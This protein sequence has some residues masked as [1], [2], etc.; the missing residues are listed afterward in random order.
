MKAE[1]VIDLLKKGKVEDALMAIDGA[2][3]RKEMAEKLIEFAGTLNYLKGHPELTEA[4]L[5]KALVLDHENADG[6]YN[7]GVLY[8]DPSV[9]VGD[10]SK[11]P[12]A[13]QAFK[14]ALEYNPDFYEARYNLALLYY[15][16]G[17]VDEAGEEYGRIT[18]AVGDDPRFRELGMLLMYDKR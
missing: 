9:L 14:F 17:R 10:E 4:L 16:T 3:D 1:E 11:L 7:L 8:T 13:E 18:D 12:K 6:Y 5:K 15:F 2:D